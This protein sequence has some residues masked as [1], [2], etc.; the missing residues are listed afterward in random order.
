MNPATEFIERAESWS[1]VH[2]YIAD[3]GEAT[4]RADIEH[5]KL[6]GR[7]VAIAADLTERERQLVADAIREVGPVRKACFAN[8][9]QTWLHSDRFEYVEGFAIYPAMECG[10]EHAW[11]LLDGEMLVD[12]TAP[13]DHYYGVT[14]TDEG[15]LRRHACESD[16]SHGIIGDHRHRFKFLR[17]RGYVDG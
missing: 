4:T 15:V 13:F 1:P 2:A 7:D 9:L 10:I 12:V 3:H 14:V 6:A 16:M 11:C 8:A 5:A 17:E